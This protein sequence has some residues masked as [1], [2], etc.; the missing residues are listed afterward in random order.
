MSS[1]HDIVLRDLSDQY[2]DI[3]R[4][5]RPQEDTSTTNSLPRADGGKHAWLFL[6]ACTSIEA[7]VWGQ[8]ESALGPF[9]SIKT[10][11]TFHTFNRG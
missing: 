8:F 5:P 10:S 1:A 6:A 7:V 3:G 4:S 2:V 9:L 11:V